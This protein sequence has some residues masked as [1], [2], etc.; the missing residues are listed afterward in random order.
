MNDNKYLNPIWDEHGLRY[1]PYICTDNGD[2]NWMAFIFDD[3]YDTYLNSLTLEQRY[4]ELLL[5]IL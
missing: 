1:N 5:L 2:N 4:E 3:D